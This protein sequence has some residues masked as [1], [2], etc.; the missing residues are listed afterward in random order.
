MLFLTRALVFGLA[1]LSSLTTIVMRY[2]NAPKTKVLVINDEK[3]LRE[4]LQKV[5]DNTVVAFDWETLGLDYNAYPTVLA[6]HAD[7]FLPVVVPTGVCG[8]DGIGLPTL[9]KVM[10][11]EFKRFRNIAHNAKFDTMIN[12]VTLKV[13]DKNFPIHADTLVMVHLYS[14]DLDKNLEK[15]VASDLGYKKKTFKEIIGKDWSKVNWDVEWSAICDELYKYAG[16]DV[17]FTTQLYHLYAKMLDE[18]GWRLHDRV[19]IPLMYILRDAKI[20]GVEINVELLQKFATDAEDILNKAVQNIYDI[21]GCTFNLNSPKQKEAVFFD[22]LGLPSFGTTRGGARSTDKNVM[23]EWADMGIPIGVE[24]LKFSE[25]STLLKSFILAIPKMLDEHNVLRGD[26]N[27]CGTETGRCSSSNPNL[28]NQPNN[29]DFPVREAFKAREGYVFVNYDYSQLELRVMAHCSKDPLFIEIFKNG[30]DPHSEVAQQIGI[31][32]KG[33]KTVNFGVLYGM[34]PEKLA[35]TIDVPVAEAKRIIQVDYMNA[36]KGFASWKRSTEK[37]AEE[38]GYVKTL[39]GR[40]R[41]LEHAKNARNK[42]MYFQAMRQSVNT[43]IQGSGADIVKIS[44]IASVKALKEAGLDAHFLLQVHDELLFEVREDQMI[45]AERIIKQCMEHTV[46][47][48]IPLD[49]DGKIVRNWWE[50]K[51]DSVPSVPNRFDYSLISTIM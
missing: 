20:R 51:L 27:S 25:L 2:L 31:S 18:D 4:Y 12:K 36:Y 3:E 46:K 1:S 38:N 24:L 43:I 47:L 30:R 15:R 22:K 8:D 37:F 34:G 7:G 21:A 40:I 26:I 41:R 39:F 42:G 11:S 17:F 14:P 10:N 44:T 35:H 49:I 23:A 33:A 6:I 16:E 45:E 19:E 13:E 50:A 9:S 29:Y 5:P 28:Q 48:C 32:R